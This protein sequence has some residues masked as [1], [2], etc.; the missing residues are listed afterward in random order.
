MKYPRCGRESLSG[1][2]YCGFS[3]LA[4]DRQF[5]LYLDWQK[6]GEIVELKWRFAQM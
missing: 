5:A 6:N 3:G 2:V 4:L 1:V